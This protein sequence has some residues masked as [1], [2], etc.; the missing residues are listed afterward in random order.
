[1]DYDDDNDVKI[2]Q[3]ISFRPP[4]H[5]CLLAFRDD[6]MAITFEEWWNAT[7]KTLWRDY[8]EKNKHR[9]E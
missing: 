7:G 9:Y 1:M 8:H 4:D 2:L 3:M 5:E 6:V